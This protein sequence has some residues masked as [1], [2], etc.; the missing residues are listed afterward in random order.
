MKMGTL[1]EVTDFKIWNDSHCMLKDARGVWGVSAAAAKPFHR[2]GGHCVIDIP[3]TL[4][5]GGCLSKR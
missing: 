4:I 1:W 5:K 3:Q 2:S